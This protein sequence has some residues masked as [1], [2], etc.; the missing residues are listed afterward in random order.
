MDKSPEAV[1]RRHHAQVSTLGL[2][3]MMWA[4]VELVMEMVIKQ[5]LNLTHE[6]VSIICGPLGGGAKFN[7]LS[8]LTAGNPE[9]EDFVNA[10]RAFQAKVGRNALAH[11]FITFTEADSPWE[12]ISRDVKNS[13]TV[14]RR[15]LIDYYNEDFMPAFDRV[16]AASG[17][18]DQD[19]HSY[20]Q[21]LAALAPTR[22]APA[23][24]PQ[25]SSSLR[26]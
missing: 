2:V 19:L 14:K 6:Q 4:N 26:S 17:F 25:A 21:E 9:R 11:G 16:M 1:N 7:L 15:R 22:P 8:S 23:P 10:V 12:V 5:E 18:S 24:S 3:L 20:G 13:L